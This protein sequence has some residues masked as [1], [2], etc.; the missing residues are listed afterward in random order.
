MK[1]LFFILAL[2]ALCGAA[3]AN[4]ISDPE[5]TLTGWRYS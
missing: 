2:A 3:F 1:K 5:V 4:N